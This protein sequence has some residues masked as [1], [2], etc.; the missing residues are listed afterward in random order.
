MKMNAMAQDNAQTIVTLREFIINTYKNK[1]ELFFL[2]FV[3]FV[4]HR[5]MSSATASNVASR[6]IKPTAAAA[7]A[8][9]AASGLTSEFV[10]GMLSN[11]QLNLTEYQVKV[12][13]MEEE[14][15]TLKIENNLLRNHVRELTRDQQ[16]QRR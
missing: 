6:F 8:A 1:I 7:A 2:R 16:Q 4:F 11:I 9:A 13:E 15:R 5:A 10:L 12:L 3:S 14:L